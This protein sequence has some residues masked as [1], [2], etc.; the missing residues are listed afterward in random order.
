MCDI[1]LAG[2]TDFVCSYVES[3]SE[4]FIADDDTTSAV[5]PTRRGDHEK[6]YGKRNH[7]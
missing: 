6:T 3:N 1:Q 4:R 5:W 7:R 2:Y